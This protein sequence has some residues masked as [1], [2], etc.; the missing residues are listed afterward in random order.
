M[1]TDS[2]PTKTTGWD[3]AAA[4]DWVQVDRGSDRF[5]YP[6]QLAATLASHED[7]I[8]RVLDVAS[9]PGGFLATVLGRVVRLLRDDAGDGDREPRTLR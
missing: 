4:R 8:G 7:Q 1:T 5:A 6:W 2:A 9:G 3:E